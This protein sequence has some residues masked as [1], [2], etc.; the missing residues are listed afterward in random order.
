MPRLLF[1][2]TAI[3]MTAAVLSGC[4][5]GA[6]EASAPAS[7]PAATSPAESATPSTPPA[8]DDAVASTQPKGSGETG[9]FR[10]P[11]AAR[12]DGLAVVSPQT[13]LQVADT[14]DDWTLTARERDPDDG[15]CLLADTAGVEDPPRACY[16]GTELALQ[17]FGDQA[18]ARGIA[19]VDQIQTAPRG[20]K[21]RLLVSG[22]VA[23]DVDEVVVRY[24]TTRATAKLSARA[25]KL[26]IDRALA[27]LYSSATASELDRLPASFPVRIFAVSLPRMS[28]N[29][30]RS[31][32]PQS[33]APVRGTLTFA[34]Q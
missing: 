18:Q 22:V 27:E 3:A 10:V 6:Q 14:T 4:G 28:K 13:G 20:G 5:G 7:A 33:Y 31:A 26:P 24:G 11:R 16:E 23:A 1:A 17:F 15:L 2:A 21:P 12:G 8:P 29:P 25:I 9:D 34:L 32:V 30:P 19:Q